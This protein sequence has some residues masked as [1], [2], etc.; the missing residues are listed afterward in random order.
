MANS[1]EM[2]RGVHGVVQ[3]VGVAIALFSLSM[4]ALAQLSPNPPSDRPLSIQAR[5][6]AKIDAAIVPYV[7]E[8][9][10]SFPAAKSRFLHGLP[11]DQAFFVTVQLRDA[12]G[13]TERVFVQVAEIQG[14][15]VFG[16]IANG[17]SLVDGFKAGQQYSVDE[18]DILDWLI[19]KSDGSEEG[20]FVGKFLDTYRP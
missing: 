9:R 13:R 16:S 19:A 4:G 11:S 10:K 18:S 15:T 7:A 6:A 2:K 20:N 3:Q 12:K 5:E 8:A 14:T 17:I 1:S